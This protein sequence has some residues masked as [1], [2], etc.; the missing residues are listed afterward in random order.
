MKKLNF[1]TQKIA[2]L[3]KKVSS[4]IFGGDN[5]TN[6]CNTGESKAPGQSE[7]QTL[8]TCTLNTLVDCG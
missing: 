4:K 8:D 6:D 1:K 5:N 2:I 7:N 3:N